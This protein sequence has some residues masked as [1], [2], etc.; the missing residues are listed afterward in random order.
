MLKEIFLNKDIFA[1]DTG[2][3]NNIWCFLR[4]TDICV[5][6]ISAHDT[7]AQDSILVFGIT[8]ILTLTFVTVHNLTLTLPLRVN[9]VHDQQA[10]RQ[11]CEVLML[12]H[13]IYKYVL[14]VVL[15]CYS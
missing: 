9:V 7:Y 12:Y 3:N 5:R 6:N 8:H 4:F 11:T 10:G 14:L 2:D 1:F 13:Q 15:R